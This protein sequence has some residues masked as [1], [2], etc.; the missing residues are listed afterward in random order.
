[1]VLSGKKMGKLVGVRFGKRSPERRWG[2]FYPELGH[3]EKI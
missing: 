3:T 2:S 1:M